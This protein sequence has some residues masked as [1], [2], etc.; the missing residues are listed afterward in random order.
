MTL[1]KNDESKG[2]KVLIDKTRDARAA[3]ALSP[4]FAMSLGGK[5][6]FHT[7]F[8]AFLLETNDVE[9]DAL[10]RALRE[11]LS[12]PV[13]D[14]E[15]STC[16][17]W[18]EKGNLDFIAIPL[19]SGTEQEAEA[20]PVKNRALM[21][22]AKM[23]SIPTKEQL[24][25]YLQKD[26]KIS[27]PEDTQEFKIT[28]HMRDR[29]QPQD[30]LVLR[31]LTPTG[32]TVHRLWIGIQWGTVATAIQNNVQAAP[33][34]LQAILTDYAQ[35][36]QH[37]VSLVNTVYERVDEA[38]SE[39]GR[40]KYKCLYDELTHV[41]F[42]KI[43][44]HDLTGKAGFDALLR[45]ITTYLPQHNENAT[46]TFIRY[47]HFS[48]SQP[49]LTIEIPVDPNYRLGVQIQGSSYRHFLSCVKDDKTL[50]TLATGT[51]LWSE[52]FNTAVGGC[53]LK[54]CNDDLLVQYD[55]FKKERR[56]NL[57][58]F[59]PNRFLYS[60]FSLNDWTLE[61]LA[62]AVR[63][64]MAKAVTLSSDWNNAPGHR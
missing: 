9:L 40:M 47:V 14:N 37:M 39:R 32:E 60:A 30:S 19:M 38:W 20:V 46:D 27:Y 7:N 61:Q 52:W 45:H 12:F 5:E 24:E 34:S 50:E 59:N 51:R 43:R 53:N 8:L 25:K 35:S 13:F 44:L 17:V 4:T 26:I 28:L 62:Q 6:L 36:L 57:R 58:V 41:E 3:L 29:T 33:A 31:L 55:S 15:L 56:T 48:R 2:E 16:I 18:R 63:A 21:V 54:G 23:K 11:A 49:G 64:S 42:R 22:E 1:L 10:R